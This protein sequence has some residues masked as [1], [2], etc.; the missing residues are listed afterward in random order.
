MSLT[1]PLYGIAA[2]RP[3]SSRSRSVGIEQASVT[4]QRTSVHFDGGVGKE[5]PAHR[6]AAY[7]S[8]ELAVIANTQAPHA[9]TVTVVGQRGAARGIIELRVEAQRE[10][11]KADDRIVLA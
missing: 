8:A 2:R 9:R 10:F 7:L 5:E 3:V 4:A 11:A 1:A 6:A